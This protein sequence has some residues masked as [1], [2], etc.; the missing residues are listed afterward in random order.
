ME[1]GLESRQ[2]FESAVQLNGT[3]PHRFISCVSDT[4]TDKSLTFARHP[5]GASC[6]LAIFGCAVFDFIP[7][8][9][10]QIRHCWPGLMT[11]ALMLQTFS[12]SRLIF[13]IQTA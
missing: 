9:R 5:V 11:A 13:G 12:V 8:G 3:A 10:L 1:F 6:K 7:D 4:T 2:N